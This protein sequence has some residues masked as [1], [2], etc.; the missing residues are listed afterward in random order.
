MVD[1]PQC[2]SRDDEDEIVPAAKQQKIWN[3][4]YAIGGAA[5]TIAQFEQMTGMPSATSA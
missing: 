5:C 2:R 3:A 1:R 4:A